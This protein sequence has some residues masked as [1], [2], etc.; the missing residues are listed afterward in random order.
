MSMYLKIK[1]KNINFWVN[2]CSKNNN[3]AII[4]YEDKQ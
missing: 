3:Y 1:I 2:L 4:G